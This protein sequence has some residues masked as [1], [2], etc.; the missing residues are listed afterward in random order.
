MSEGLS[1]AAAAKAAVAETYQ[2]RGKAP[3]DRATAGMTKT[4]TDTNGKYVLSV[5]VV[6]AE[7]SINYGN[8]AHTNV[9]GKTLVLT[10]FV[11][12]DDSDGS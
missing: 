6:T 9:T 12:Q 10:P 1:L 8:D 11:S 3:A 4:K 5:D 2:A 7:V